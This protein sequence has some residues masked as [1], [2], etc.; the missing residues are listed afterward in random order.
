MNKGSTTHCSQRGGYA[1]GD[2]TG[3]EAC[4][5]HTGST[6]AGTVAAAPGMHPDG[7]GRGALLAG[8]VAVVGL[9]AARAGL[10]LDDALAAVATLPEYI[11]V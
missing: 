5:H 11:N 10:Q 8:L 6:R 7:R 9:L 3:G 2:T 1:E 4:S